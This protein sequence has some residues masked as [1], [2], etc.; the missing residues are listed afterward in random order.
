VGVTEEGQEVDDERKMRR[1]RRRKRRRRRRR[2]GERRG[3]R[4]RQLLPDAASAA[5]DNPDVGLIHDT[6]AGKQH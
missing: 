1:R 6:H 4:G 2:R 5:N 3:G